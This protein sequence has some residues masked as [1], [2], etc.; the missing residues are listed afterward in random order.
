[1][2]NVATPGSS[3]QAL[4]ALFLSPGPE[5]VASAGLP[6][7][8]RAQLLDANG[9]PVNG[10]QVT[11]SVSSDET[12]FLLD[13][14]G[15]GMYSGVLRTASGGPVA[16]TGTAIASDGTTATFGVGGD[17]QSPPEGLPVIFR[18]GIVSTANY[19]PGPTPAAA[20]SILSL[21]GASLANQSEVASAVPLPAELDGIKVLVGGIE[22]PLLSVTADAAPGSDQINF[23]LPVEAGAWTYADVVVVNNG[24][25]SDPEGI[26][27]AASIPS[28]FTLNQRGTGPA[29]ALHANFSLVGGSAPA[30]A[31]ETISLYAT[32]LGAVQ[33]PVSTGQAARSLSTVIGTVEVR[34]GGRPATVAFAGLAPGFVGLYQINVV[35]PAGLPAGEAALEVVVDGITSGE[36]ATVPIG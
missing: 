26:A 25:F 8:V 33:P 12:S 28:V 23:Q 4:Q 10:A 7:E 29:A 2:L 20:G 17:L 21:F 18:Q 6:T 13:G 15:S 30:R 11:V 36:G 19:A 34:I 35:V 1:M 5:F 32:G 9:N 3:S 22:A 16:L 24:V 27:I 31:G 14:E